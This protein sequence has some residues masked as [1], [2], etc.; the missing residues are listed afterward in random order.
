[1]KNDYNATADWY[2]LILYI[3]VC[4]WEL[5]VG[6]YGEISCCCLQDPGLDMKQLEST[7]RTPTCRKSS[8]NN[9]VQPESCGTSS[10]ILSAEMHLSRESFTRSILPMW[11]GYIVIRCVL[12]T[13]RDAK[14]KTPDWICE[15]VV[16]THEAAYLLSPRTADAPVPLE[17]VNQENCHLEL[18][19]CLWLKIK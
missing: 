4:R 11:D 16:A 10:S 17:K 14:D 5:A 18:L 13:W 1:M 19:S 6:V 12:I 15:E 7:K 2:N 9:P 3:K 8:L